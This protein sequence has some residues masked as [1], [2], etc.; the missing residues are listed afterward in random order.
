VVRTA[1]AS[2][3]ELLGRRLRALRKLRDL[4][5]EE[6]GERARVSGKFVGLIERGVGNPTLEVLA[7]LAEALR[8]SLSDLLRFEEGRPEGHVRN[9]ARAFVAQER[10]AEYLARRP[11]ADAERA[12]RILEA[13][14]GEGVPPVR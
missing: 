5:Q 8:V 4:T 1:S 3:G 9:A 7:R 2:I 11:A 6:L 14:L 10:V 12:L 13:A